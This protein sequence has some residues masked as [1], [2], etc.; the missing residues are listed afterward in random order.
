[1]L[2]RQAERLMKER[3]E[4]HRQTERETLKKERKLFME[5]TEAISGRTNIHTYRARKEKKTGRHKQQTGRDVR[6]ERKEELLIDRNK[7]WADT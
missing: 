4:C 1:M 3:G 6:R 7:R 5:Q 2:G